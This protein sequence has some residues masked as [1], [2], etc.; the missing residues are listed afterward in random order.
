MFEAN[1]QLQIFKQG[2]QYVAYSPALDLSTS[3]KTKTEA[4]KMF[5]EAAE[6]FIEEL[7]EMGTLNKVLKELGWAKA[8]RQDWRPPQIFERSTKVKVALGV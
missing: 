7:M 1:L 2:N 8:P 5:D 3:G 4:K 6:A